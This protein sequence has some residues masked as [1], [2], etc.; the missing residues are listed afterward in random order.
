MNASGIGSDVLPVS[1]AGI[2]AEAERPAAAGAWGVTG[3]S[4]RDPHAL[5]TA[6]ELPWYRKAATVGHVAAT[7]AEAYPLHPLVP[8]RCVS[9]ADETAR[10]SSG[11]DLWVP[12]PEYRD[13]PPTSSEWTAL[14]R[15]DRD[16]VLG[17]RLGWTGPGIPW[18]VEVVVANYAMAGPAL[19][20]VLGMAR[21]RRSPTA[22]WTRG[23]RTHLLFVGDDRLAD[24]GL[25]DVAGRIGPAI[26]YPGLIVR[27]GDPADLAAS[28]AILPSFPARKGGTKSPTW[29]KREQVC[30]LPESFYEELTRLAQPDGV[31]GAAGAGRRAPRPIVSRAEAHASGPPTPAGD[32]PAIDAGGSGG[33][34]HEGPPPSIPEPGEPAV[35]GRVADDPETLADE[36]NEHHRRVV[37]SAFDAL[38]AARRSGELLLR[39]KR[40]LEHG[41][42]QGW[43]E[44]HCPFSY[45]TAAS[46]MKIAKEWDKLLLS[47][48]QC[49]ALPSLG[50][51]LRMLAG[52]MRAADDR[53]PTR[54]SSSPREPG[55]SSPADPD[56]AWGDRPIA[57]RTGRATSADRPP[58]GSAPTPGDEPGDLDGIDPVRPS[59]IVMPPAPE[60]PAPPRILGVGPIAAAGVDDADRADRSVVGPSPAGIGGATVSPQSRRRAGDIVWRLRLEGIRPRLAALGNQAGFDRDATAWRLLRPVAEEFLARG[61][62]SGEGDGRLPGPIRGGLLAPGVARLARARHPSAWTLCPGCQGSGQAGT[63]QGVCP[64]CSGRGYRIEE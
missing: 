57:D 62:W 14:C 2:G 21:P 22:S 23:R 34:D 27:L 12:A 13:R 16:L 49:D 6:I 42:F 60:P 35:S 61:P 63:E 47:K 26:E 36:I 56:P 11:P 58:T 39:A 37:S 48:V 15:E 10:A 55:P 4:S 38:E 25:V 20:D 30:G 24:L 3:G 9:D 19:R 54:R 45:R 17:V 1:D 59:P 7:W 52:P 18:M 31:R 29:V 33:S 43:I 28:L 53:D 32:H 50:G 46:Y 41:Q 51:A 44:G 64:P 40:G 5:L 8:L